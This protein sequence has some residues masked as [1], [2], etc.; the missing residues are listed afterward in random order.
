M[1]EEK[2]ELWI[3][4]NLRPVADQMALDEAIFHSSARDERTRARFYHWDQDAVTVGYF[5][6][7]EKEPHLDEKIPISRR[8]T[9]GGLVEHGNDITF[10]LAFPKNSSI[11]KLTGNER[12]YQIHL[13]LSDA[14]TE[15][16][17][18]VKLVETATT[19]KGPCFSAPVLQDIV[20]PDSGEKLVG[21]AQRRS[22]GAIIHQG[23][24]R[25]PEIHRHLQA[26]WIPDF[27]EK[28]AKQILP[29]DENLR[30]ELEEDAIQLKMNRYGTEDW[31]RLSSKTRIN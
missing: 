15:S 17:V 7:F 8:M 30:K 4:T 3:D 6:D 11:S 26:Q 20:C 2:L 12:Y 25:V 29:L 16:G 1:I 28:I 22:G 19:A 10:L 14:L 13:A 31:N 27:L 9:G 5:H 21:G 18:P 23:S 24:V